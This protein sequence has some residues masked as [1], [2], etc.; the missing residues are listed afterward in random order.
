VGAFDWPVGRVSWGRNADNVVHDER[1]SAKLF[2]SYRGAAITNWGDLLDRLVSAASRCRMNF[3]AVARIV[4][5]SH[6]AAKNLRP[7]APRCATAESDLTLA[8]GVREI[9][10]N[11]VFV[12]RSPLPSIKAHRLPTLAPRQVQARV[13]PSRHHPREVSIELPDRRCLPGRRR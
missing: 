7:F 9:A 8:A 6:F 5:Q 10:A 12:Q 13:Q 11:A 4:G 3:R 2:L 1:R